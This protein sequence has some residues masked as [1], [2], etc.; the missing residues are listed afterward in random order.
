M[1][2]L[3]VPKKNSISASALRTDRGGVISSF[4]IL[5]GLSVVCVT[6]N[7]I[8]DVVKKLV[9]DSSRL[10][11]D[12]FTAPFQTDDDYAARKRKVLKT[13]PMKSCKSLEI[14]TVKQRVDS[15]GTSTWVFACYDSRDTDAAATLTAFFEG[16]ATDPMKTLG[17]M[18][19]ALGYCCLCGRALS[20]PASKNRGYGPVCAVHLAETRKWHLEHQTSE[21]DVDA[22]PNPDIRPSADEHQV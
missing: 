1:C 4:R 16:L 19:K 2:R 5:G 15:S 3:L 14:G 12:R 11:N 9:R 10:E 18:G 6:A 8:F 22:D 21:V 20:D 13:R 7:T 17:E